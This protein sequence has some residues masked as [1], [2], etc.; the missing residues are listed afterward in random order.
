MP[1]SPPT[2]L[3]AS[4]PALLHLNTTDP[5][6]CPAAPRRSRALVPFLARADGLVGDA[7]LCPQQRMWEFRAYCPLK[8]WVSRVCK[9]VVF[10]RMEADAARLNSACKELIKS[11]EL[12]HPRVTLRQWRCARQHSF[13]L[14]NPQPLIC[15]EAFHHPIL[16]HL[17][18]ILQVEILLEHP[19]PS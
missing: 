11:M 5:A 12:P 16:R 19:P 1:R 13:Y 15:N 9:D 17:W 7:L 4:I 3:G 18:N 10:Q 6:R 2:L 8:Q 14:L